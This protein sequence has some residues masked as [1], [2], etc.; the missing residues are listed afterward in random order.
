MLGPLIIDSREDQG[1]TIRQTL[2]EV[3]KHI[4]QADGYF[5]VSS[6]KCGAK[7][8]NCSEWQ[9]HMLRLVISDDDVD[10]GLNDLPHE[11]DPAKRHEY[12]A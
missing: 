11:L 4:P 8:R 12:E 3:S 7:F 1:E 9:D 10:A 2:K 5:N 6:C